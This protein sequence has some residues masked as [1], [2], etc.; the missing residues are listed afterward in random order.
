MPNLSDTH[1]EEAYKHFLTIQVEW[2]DMINATL[3]FSDHDV[4]GRP[5]R[6]IGLLNSEEDYA[7]AQHLVAEWQRFADLA[8]ERRG[9]K[10]AVSVLKEIYHPVPSLLE[11]NRYTRISRRPTHASRDYSRESLLSMYDTMISK[12]SR[13]IKNPALIAPL[14]KEREYFEHTAP[15]TMFRKRTHG[16]SEVNVELT[17][18]SGGA[19]E[20][21]RQGSHGALLFNPALKPSDIAIRESELDTYVCF[22]SRLAPI[23]CVLFENTELFTLEDLEHERAMRYAERRVASHSSAIRAVA[24]TRLRK[25]RMKYRNDPKRDKAFVDKHNAITPIRKWIQY[26]DQV[27]LERMRATGEVEFKGVGY[28]RARFLTEA[29][30]ATGYYATSVMAHRRL[31]QKAGETLYED[32]PEAKD[33]KSTPE[34]K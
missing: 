8:N 14:Q 16:F 13:G 28:M 6:Q 9:R 32:M 17:P 27:L 31:L 21:L 33:A 11:V 20:R 18:E 24:A 29:E 7:K 15:G 5:F 12:L 3:I 10:H 25:A 34:I 26:Q 22:A 1:F 19:V 2:M 30:L 4:R 23:P